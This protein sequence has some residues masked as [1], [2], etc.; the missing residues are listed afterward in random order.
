MSFT[1]V[2]FPTNPKVT[3]LLPSSSW[4]CLIVSLGPFKPHTFPVMERLAAKSRARETPPAGSS[5]TCDLATRS[6]GREVANLPFSDSATLRPSRE[7][8]R[9]RVSPFC[10]SATQRLP[11]NSQLNFVCVDSIFSCYHHVFLILGFCLECS[12]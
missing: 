8:A 9:S 1:V 10:G 4:L 2:L 5:A 3:R 12:R 6:Q 11:K 7:V